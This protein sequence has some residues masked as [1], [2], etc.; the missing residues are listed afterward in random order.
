MQESTII[1][2]SASDPCYPK[3]FAHTIPSVPKFY[4]RGNIKLLKRQPC[5]AIVGTRSITPY[6]EEATRLLARTAVQ[7]GLTI[8]SG[9]AFGV[10]KIAHQTALDNG[11][12]VIAVLPAS[13]DHIYPSSHHHLARKILSSDGLLISE[14]HPEKTPSKFHFVKR[15]RLIAA[16]SDMI[17]V[18]EAGI[19]SGSRHTVDF[20][21]QLGKPVAMVPGPINSPLSA[22]PNQQI[23]NGAPPI[24]SAEDFLDKLTYNNIP[25]ISSSQRALAKTSNPIQD[26]ILHALIQKNMTTD[27]ILQLINV[28]APEFNTHITM[29]EI[30]GFVTRLSNHEWGLAK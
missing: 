19:K 9:L 27:Q 28:P 1:T 17:I 25:F 23:N 29:L 22:Y 3:D 18:P 11:G 10:D 8:V 2:I 6:G 13:L 7:A 12:A 15:N 16:L 30:K 24:I 26:S 21:L 4:A 5:V 20:A 14:H